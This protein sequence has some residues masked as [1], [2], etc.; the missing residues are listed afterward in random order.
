MRPEAT[1]VMLLGYVR[2]LKRFE[3]VVEVL[4]TVSKI[5]GLV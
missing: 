5:E 4:M 3:T 1:V 2:I